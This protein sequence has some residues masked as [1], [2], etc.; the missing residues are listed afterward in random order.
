M[1]SLN[2]PPHDPSRYRAKQIRMIKFRQRLKLQMKI[3]ELERLAKR[4]P[5]LALSAM[6]SIMELEN[7]L[8]L[9]RN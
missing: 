4:E 1:P 7:K 3:V 8:A 2:N 5:W 6:Q 9:L